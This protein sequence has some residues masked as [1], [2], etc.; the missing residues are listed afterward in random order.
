MRLF[1]HLSERLEYDNPQKAVAWEN[2]SP[3][4]KT[5]PLHQTH[6]QIS[7]AEI[8]VQQQ[9]HQNLSGHHNTCGEFFSCVFFCSGVLV[10]LI[11]S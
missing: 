3:M 5:H 9:L 2:G 11:F 7:C 1:T 4:G 10:Q 8:L 6:H